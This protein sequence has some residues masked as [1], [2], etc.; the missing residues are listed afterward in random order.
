MMDE[1]SGDS[2]RETSEA[3]RIAILFAVGICCKTKAELV[4]MIVDLGEEA[5]MSLLQQLAASQESLKAA[6]QILEGAE[7]R[8]IC[9]GSV[10]EI[11]GAGLNRA[12]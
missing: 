3:N 10:L 11:E 9:A 4:Q 6:L 2:G 8:L 7:A 12:T 5:A 1:A